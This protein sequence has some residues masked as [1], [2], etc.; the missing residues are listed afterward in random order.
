[1][2]KTKVVRSGIFSAIRKRMLKACIERATRKIE[3]KMDFKLIWQN[4]I[5]KRSRGKRQN[6]IGNGS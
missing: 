6:N 5:I 4:F 1:M 3:N 2:S